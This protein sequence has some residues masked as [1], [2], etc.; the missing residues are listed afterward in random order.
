MAAQYE[1]KFVRLKRVGFVQSLRRLET[2]AMDI[3]QETVHEYV[4]QGWRLVQIF[5]PGTGLIGEAQFFDIIFER[6]VT[7]TI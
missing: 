1:Y 5:A 3:Y 6:P 4:S 7:P 2:P